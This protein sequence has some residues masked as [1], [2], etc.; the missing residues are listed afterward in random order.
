M[1]KNN[2]KITNLECEACVKLSIATLKS[3]SGVENIKVDLKTGATEI[4][5]TQELNWGDIKSSLLKVGKNV[6]K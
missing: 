2:F 4:E 3:L 6:E 5:S 1:F